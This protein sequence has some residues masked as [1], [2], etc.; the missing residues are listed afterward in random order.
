MMTKTECISKSN[1]NFRS[2]RIKSGTKEMIDKKLGVINRPGEFGKINYD[3]LIYFLLNTMT[4]ESI[5]ELQSSTITWKYEEPRLMKLWA[6]KNGK[7]TL[8]QWKEM[9]Y[10]GRLQE[11]IKENSRIEIR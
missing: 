8:D 10:L 1:T 5:Q 3:K 6:K 11:F 4:S 2:I 7:V 9:L